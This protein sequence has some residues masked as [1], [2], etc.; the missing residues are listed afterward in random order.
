MRALKKGLLI[1]VGRHDDER[2]GTVVGLMIIQ[3]MGECVYVYGEKYSNYN[4]RYIT[5]IVTDTI[6]IQA[7]CLALA[8]RDA[9]LLIRV[10]L[11]LLVIL[12]WLYL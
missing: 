4:N 9:M 5:T 10:L 7:Q 2:G 8:H 6:L 11:P 12:L 3:C 1:V